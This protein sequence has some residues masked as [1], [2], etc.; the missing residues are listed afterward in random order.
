M[1]TGWVRA[2]GKGGARRA[3]DPRHEPA[4]V[5]TGPP[6][7]RGGPEGAGIRGCGARQWWGPEVVGPGT[8]GAT[9]RIRCGQRT[10][11]MGRIASAPISERAPP[12][13]NS[14]V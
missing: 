3:R 14:G 10:L 9:G 1:R 5:R 6:P 7:G 2:A 12:T 13:R 8:A 4:G 11:R